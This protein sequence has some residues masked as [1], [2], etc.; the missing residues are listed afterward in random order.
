MNPTRKK[1]NLK[2]NSCGHST[3]KNKITTF[4]LQTFSGKVLNVGRVAVK[5]CLNCHEIVPT[6]AGKEKLERCLNA[7]FSLPSSNSTLF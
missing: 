4:P 3:F 1:T 6:S 2:C 5:E 7:F